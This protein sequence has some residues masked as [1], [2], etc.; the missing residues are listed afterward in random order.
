MYTRRSL[1][2][3][4]THSP[5]LPESDGD[6]VLPIGD[7]PLRPTIRYLPLFVTTKTDE[8]P[9]PLKPPLLC[10]VRL[11]S[12]G[13]Q[14]RHSRRDSSRGKVPGS[15]CACGPSTP[16]ETSTRRTSRVGP[17]LTGGESQRG[18]RPD[19]K[20]GTTAGTEVNGGKHP[21]SIVPVP[22]VAVLRPRRSKT[23]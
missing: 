3:Y 22:T 19:R 2:P 4:P 21:P 6:R 10:K 11:S 1:D 14:H 18:R 5:T 9:S 16:S 23:K 15:T 20:S 7:V 8:S 17:R 13:V 12:T